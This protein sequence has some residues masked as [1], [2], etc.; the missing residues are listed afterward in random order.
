MI[1]VVNNTSLA[2]DIAKNYVIQDMNN[3][4]QNDILM[5]DA[6]NIYLKYAN[7]KSEELSQGGNHLTRFY[8]R[9]YI[10]QNNSSKRWIDNMQ[11]LINN[12]TKGYLTLQDSTLLKVCDQNQEV[13]NF[14]TQ[15]QTFDTLQLGWKNSIS[16]GDNVDGYIIKFTHK[17]DNFFDRVQTYSFFGNLTTDT[18]Y[19]LVLPNGTTYDTG[20]LRV[21]N[22][23]KKI[24]SLMTGTILAV[25]YFDPA[26]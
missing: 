24:T 6:N 10:Y 8:T 7:Q 18:S 21:E 22:V 13:K 9:Y 15:G 17:I 19:I 16:L 4:H 23:N 2:T 11:D 14:E 5:W 20:I 3:D 1:N 12:T 25:K 26:Q